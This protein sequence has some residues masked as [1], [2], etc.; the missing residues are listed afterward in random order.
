MITTIEFIFFIFLT[1]FIFLKSIGFAI[2][3]IKEQNNK[4]GGIYVICFSLFTSILS[5][6][7]LILA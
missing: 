5:C 7:A 1:V 3:E 2:Y 6:I 4:L